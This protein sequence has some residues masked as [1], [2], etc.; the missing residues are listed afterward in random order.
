MSNLATMNSVYPFGDVGDG[1]FTDLQ[2][3]DVPWKES[4]IDEALDIVYYSMSGEKSVTNIILKRLDEDG[5]L[6]TTAR[7]EIANSLFALFGTQW[8]KLYETLSFEYD[9]IENYRLTESEAIAKHDEGSN[10]DSG[11]IDRDATNSRTDSGTIDRDAT[12]SRT[13][14]GTIDRDA[15]NSRTDSG[16]VEKDG[17][18][19]DI[20][21]K[22]YGFNSSTAVNSDESENGIDLTETH[23]LTFGESVDETETHD[24]TF[25]E[26]VDET[27]THDL[28]FGESVD[29]TETHDLTYTNE[30]DS[31]INRSFTRSGNIGVTTSQQMIAS[32]RELWR[33]NF[34]NVVFRDIDSILCLPI[35]SY[36]MECD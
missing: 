17:T 16:T 15:T 18:Q 13:D 6:P 21:N 5:E 32:E 26:S 35:Y 30:Q 22:V 23:D 8:A 1:I 20:T 2:S 27:E 34:F 9:P 19:A 4:D 3:L 10:T 14:S 11:T 31:S 29:E 36:E 12:N 25:G 33:W 7:T 28:I 24:L